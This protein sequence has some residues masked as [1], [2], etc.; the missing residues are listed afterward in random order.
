[1]AL[2]LLIENVCRYVNVVPEVSKFEAIFK[3]NYKELFDDAKHHQHH[4]WHLFTMASC[5]AN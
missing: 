3:A 5:V 4:R 2:S 1:M